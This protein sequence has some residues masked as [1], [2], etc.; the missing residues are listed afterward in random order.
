[1]GGIQKQAKAVKQDHGWAMQLW[2]TKAHYPRMLAIWVLDKKQP[3]QGVIDQLAAD[4]LQHAVVQRAW[5][6]SP[7]CHAA[8]V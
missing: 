8:L 1:M 5:P 7:A 4:M 2:Q 6:Q 3:T